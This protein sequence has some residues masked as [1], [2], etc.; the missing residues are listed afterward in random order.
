M[1]SLSCLSPFQAKTTWLPS[2]ENEGCEWPPGCVVNGTD[3]S[4]S[5]LCGG[6]DVRQKNTPA[7]DT[8]T[9]AIST[10]GTGERKRCSCL[11]ETESCSTS[12]SATFRSAIVW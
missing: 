2:G 4:G 6:R 12:S 9:S 10:Q 8:G 3:R 11:P 7:S 1:S 5:V